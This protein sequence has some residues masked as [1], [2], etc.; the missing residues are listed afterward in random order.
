MHAPP[1]LKPKPK[2]CALPTGARTV[3][4]EIQPREPVQHNGEAAPG[5]GHDFSRI[6]VYPPVANALQAEPTI[7]EPGGHY[8]Q[9]ADRVADKVMTVPESLLRL[10]G[11]CGRPT[12]NSCRFTTAT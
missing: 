6:S 12:T 5:L 9:E 1:Q 4:P 2:A 7:G 8:E 11:A 10:S 3:R